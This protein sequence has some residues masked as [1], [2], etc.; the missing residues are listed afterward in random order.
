MNDIDLQYLMNGYA[1]KSYAQSVMVD[2][3]PGKTYTIYEPL[4]ITAGA[5]GENF[6]IIVR[7]NGAVL[8]YAG[9]KGKGPAFQIG[10]YD[11]DK[12]ALYCSF[13][14]IEFSATP[15]GADELLRLDYGNFC[16]FRNVNVRCPG[17]RSVAVGVQIENQQSLKLDQFSVN[18][19]DV[20]VKCGRIANVINWQS[21]KVVD[22]GVGIYLDSSTGNIN[23]VDISKCENAI[24]FDKCSQYR[25]HCYTEGITGTCYV[26]RNSKHVDISGL[27]NSLGQYGIEVINSQYVRVE[28][29]ESRVQRENLVSKDASS[30]VEIHDYAQPMKP[31][32]VVPPVINTDTP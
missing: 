13:E 27:I 28:N 5:V 24:I 15:E 18:F 14:D 20:G 19:A 2:L 16:S 8:Q 17:A 31:I 7:G 6:R 10:D 23:C 9:G 22:C 21:G 29:I 32:V 25:V 12:K 4:K 11:E 1:P 26:V 3:R 30:I